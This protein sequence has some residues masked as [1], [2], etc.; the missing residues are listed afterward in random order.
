[1]KIDVWHNI[2]WSRYKGA[3][4]SALYRRAK[5]Q[6]IDIRFF[7]IAETDNQRQSLNDVDRSYHQYPFKVLFYGPYEKVSRLQLCFRLFEQTFW[8]SADLTVICGYHRIEYWVQLLILM[9]QGRHRGVFCD[10]TAADQPRTL[11]KGIFKQFFFRRCHVIFCY[12]VRSMDYVLSYGVEPSKVR[13]RCQAAALPIGYS[14]KQAVAQ[15][16]ENVSTSPLFLYVGRLSA[17]KNL[18]RLIEAFALAYRQIPQARLRLV[19]NGPLRCELHSLV[20]AHGV[21]DAVCF[22]GSLDQSELTQEYLRAKCL[23]LPSLSE[24]WGLVVNEALAFGCPALVSDRCGCC[25]ELIIEGVSGF[26]FDPMD[27]VALANK[28]ILAASYWTDTTQTA[29]V[30]TNIVGKYTPAAAANQILEGCEAV[31]SAK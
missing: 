31:V 23:V 4:F 6:G 20:N 26:T 7:Q 24:P 3:V 25:P 14:A 2:L 21:T 15:R 16:A 5:S 19:G 30:C 1:M 13:F 27:P 28:M 17:E 18:A 11:L 10:A 29:L 8:S 22:A 9:L 12:G